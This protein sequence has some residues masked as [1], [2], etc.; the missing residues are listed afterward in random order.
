[1]KVAHI[2]GPELQLEGLI[3]KWL[4]THPLAAVQKLQRLGVNELAILYRE[5]TPIANL[6]STLPP[7]PPPIPPFEGGPDAPVAPTRPVSLFADDAD[8]PPL[9]DPVYS[10]LTLPR[11]EGA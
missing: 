3:L 7:P 6:Y 11:E 1:M 2:I 4:A 5:E 8:A 9:P 10:S